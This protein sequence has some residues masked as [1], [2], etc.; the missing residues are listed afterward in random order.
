MLPG[1]IYVETVSE[2]GGVGKFN[3]AIQTYYQGLQT[4]S[5]LFLLEDV[6][7]ADGFVQNVNVYSVGKYTEAFGSNYKRNMFRYFNI[8]SK[9]LA[10]KMSDEEKLFFGWAYR[11]KMYLK[12]LSSLGSSKYALAEANYLNAKIEALSSLGAYGATVLSMFNDLQERAKAI[13]GKELTARDLNDLLDIILD[14]MASK[15]PEMTK[16]YHSTIHGATLAYGSELKNITQSNIEAA[17]EKTKN[18]SK[19]EENYIVLNGKTR[20][21][22]PPK[23]N[24]KKKEK[25]D[26]K[27]KENKKKPSSAS[28]K[29]LKTEAIK[30][31]VNN[32][33]SNSVTRTDLTE[34]QNQVNNEQTKRIIQ[35]NG[36]SFLQ[37]QG[38]TPEIKKVNNQQSLTNE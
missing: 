17:E 13:L 25:K 35:V 33:E 9:E 18:I 34:L 31:P 7:K 19:K 38:E 12:M 16:I 27:K 24:N 22:T 23:N 20:K 5:E 28:L 37:K 1:V 30:P 15:Y 3:F 32:E 11:R 6:K 14:D 10:M 8:V 26:D 21:I 2:F 29:P 4:S 36:Q